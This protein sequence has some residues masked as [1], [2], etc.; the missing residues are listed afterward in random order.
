MEHLGKQTDL[1]VESTSVLP[2]EPESFARVEAELERVSPGSQARHEV[3]QKKCR[4]PVRGRSWK[5]NNSYIA[6]D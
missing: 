6:T 4:K 1:K 2:M 3:N 5:Q